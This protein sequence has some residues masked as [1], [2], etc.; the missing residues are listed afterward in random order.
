MEI[1]RQRKM[2][3]ILHSKSVIQPEMALE[4][5]P[6]LRTSRII[7]RAQCKMKCKSPC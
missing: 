4:P 6:L 1:Q 5:G 2:Y 7:C 3:P